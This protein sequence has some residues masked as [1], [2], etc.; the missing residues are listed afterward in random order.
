MEASLHT[1]LCRGLDPPSDCPEDKKSVTQQLAVAGVSCLLA[2]FGRWGS[3]SCD[4]VPALVL[5]YCFLPN[6][7]VYLY[8]SEC[9]WFD[10]YQPRNPSQRAKKGKSKKEEKEEDRR[11]PTSRWF[12]H[13]LFQ[14][15]ARVANRVRTRDSGNSLDRVPG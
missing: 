1:R 15:D 12:Q 5:S 7:I 9:I 2:T 13:Q 6:M 4:H 11:S 3:F 14:P 8:V 10:G